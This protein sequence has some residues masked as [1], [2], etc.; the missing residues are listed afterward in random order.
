MIRN[1]HI[2]V[3]LEL[4]EYEGVFTTAQ[5]ARMGVPRDALHDAV[6][7]GRLERIMRGAYRLIGSG[8][9]ETDELTAIW[10]LTAPSMFTH[11]RAQADAWDG[12]V[13]GGATAASVL[14]IGD[15]F[16]SPYRIY[17]PRRFN[18]RNRAT[19][20][21][22]R[23]IERDDVTFEHDV[24]VTRPE[25]TVF[26]LIL[27]YEDGSLVADALRDACSGPM[28]FDFDRLRELLDSKYGKSK[29]A[30]LFESLMADAD[31]STL[32]LCRAV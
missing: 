18:T 12:I 13:I 21:G 8:A 2:S 15:F 6:E 5:A 10:K 1:D 25:R 30:N 27:D 19:R 31:V 23:R 32:A 20:F 7:A 28:Q 22:V 26:D 17:A 9:R 16:L 11:E 3:I 24:P 29:G 4:S 14:D